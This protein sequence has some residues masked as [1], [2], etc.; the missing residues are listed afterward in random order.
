MQPNFKDRRTKIT[1]LPSFPNQSIRIWMINKDLPVHKWVQILGLRLW[2]QF[3]RKIRHPLLIH[4]HFP[5]KMLVVAASI[6]MRYLFTIYWQTFMYPMTKIK[7]LMMTPSQQLMWKQQ[8]KLPITKQQ[9]KIMTNYSS[10]QS[11][12]LDPTTTIQ[13]LI[14]YHQ[15]LEACYPRRI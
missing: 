2:S 10:K 9:V 12:A 4:L 14:P 3:H 15:T 13:N 11:K 7:F 8:P 1:L 5:R 6:Y